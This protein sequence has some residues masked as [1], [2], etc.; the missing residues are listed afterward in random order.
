MLAIK[1]ILDAELPK[2]EGNQEAVGLDY[3]LFH[4]TLFLAIFFLLDDGRV[5]LKVLSTDG[6]KVFTEVTV[7]GHYQQ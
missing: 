7:G 1:F 3:K 4:K 5:Q 2:G 6:A